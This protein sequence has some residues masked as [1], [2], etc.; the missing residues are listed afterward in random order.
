MGTFAKLAM[1]VGLAFAGLAAARHYPCCPSPRAGA[2]ATAAR[3]S[4]TISTAALTVD[5]M[6]CASCS[7]AVRTALGRLDGIRDVR[8]NVGAKRT[9]IEY[10]PARVT[11]QQL[12][13]AVN[14]L[15]Y[16]AS[17]VPE[18]LHG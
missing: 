6:T 10:E 12:V 3:P 4:P 11:P 18:G 14:R 5:G 16:R 9:V 15:G 8:V 1:S 17:L 7:L 13:D 2:E